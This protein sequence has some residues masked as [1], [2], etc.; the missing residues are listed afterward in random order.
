MENAIKIARYHTKRSAVIAFVGGFHGRTLAC[1]T[2]TG[3]VSALQ[4][5]LRPDAAGRLPRALPMAYHGVS[6][7]DSLSAID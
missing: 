5:G 7:D 6:V 4:G 2:L 3:K 1:I